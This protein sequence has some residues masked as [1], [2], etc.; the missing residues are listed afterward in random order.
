MNK[1]YS[2]VACV[3][4]EDGTTYDQIITYLTEKQMQNNALVERLVKRF[5]NSLGKGYYVACTW[6]E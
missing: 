2:L 6:I 3:E 4:R 1:I 5:S